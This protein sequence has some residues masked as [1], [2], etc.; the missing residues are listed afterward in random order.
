MHNR[1]IAYGIMMFGQ[2][3][4]DQVLKHSED[5]TLQN[6]SYFA[7]LFL[8]FAILSFLDASESRRY[9]VLFL[10]FFVV[11]AIRFLLNL[12]CITCTKQ[13]YDQVVNNDLVDYVTW[14]ILAAFLIKFLWLNR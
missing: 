1:V 9:N 6:I 12:A 2:V 10:G 11:F 5:Y 7:P 8:S 14:F 3:L 4:Y 13:V